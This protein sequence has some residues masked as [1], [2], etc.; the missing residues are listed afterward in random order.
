MKPSFWPF[1]W[2]F[3]C[4]A[5]EFWLLCLFLAALLLKH[6]LPTAAWFDVVTTLLLLV[7]TCC[8][9]LNMVHALAGLQ[10]VPR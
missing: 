8:N 7:L 2:G 4:S 6:Y 1:T 10:P 5:C 9:I 3:G